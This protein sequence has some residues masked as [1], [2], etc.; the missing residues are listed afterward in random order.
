[1]GLLFTCTVKGTIYKIHRAYCTASVIVSVVKVELV[2][3]LMHMVVSFGELGY[4]AGMNL[5]LLISE[6]S[7]N[8]FCIKI[9]IK[10]FCCLK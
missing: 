5:P 10:T 4:I 2:M 8:P 9:N 6:I 1:M 7:G 3:N